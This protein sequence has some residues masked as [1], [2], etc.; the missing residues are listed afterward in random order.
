MLQ[1]SMQSELETVVFQVTTRCPYQC[2]Q[3]YMERGNLQLPLEFAKEVIDIAHSNR[4]Q[5][6]QI[7]GGEPILYDH[8][9]ALI[10]YANNYGM[11]SFMA[12][13]GYGS[14]WEQYKKLKRCGLSVLCVSINN[15]VEIENSKSR[16]MYEESISAIKTAVR[17]G[18][19][20]FANVVVS[21]E[22]IGQLDLL[23]DYLSNI[24]VQGINLLRPVRSY[25]GKY[26]P[27]ISDVT[28]ETLS[29]IVKNRPDLFFVERCFGE[30]WSYESGSAFNCKEAGKNTFFVNADCSF[31]LCSK[32][33]QHRFESIEDMV[34]YAANQAVRCSAPLNT[35]NVH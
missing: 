7:T 15:I 35:K 33:N 9:L 3:C 21:D 17:C 27:K 25:D 5:A 2:P 30:F 32:M 34:K 10:S 26:M 20:C 12:T 24:G 31:S 14:S 29:K 23:G 18:I 11:Y 4:A 16:M 22:N 28:L 19:C 13:S 8:L 1:N 6:I